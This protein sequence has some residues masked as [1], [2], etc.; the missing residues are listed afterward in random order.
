[1]VF[2]IPYKIFIFLLKYIFYRYPI[3]IRIILIISAYKS[4]SNKYKSL[5]KNIKY[6]I[7]LII[8]NNIIK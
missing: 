5:F 8:Y 7:I 2:L 6:I 4:L 1:M 3:Y